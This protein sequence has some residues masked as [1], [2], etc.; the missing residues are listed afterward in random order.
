[1][2]SNDDRH[3]QLV[4]AAEA[5]RGWVRG[6]RAEWDDV[7]LGIPMDTPAPFAAVYAPRSAPPAAVEVVV[8]PAMPLPQTPIA[9]ETGSDEV[10]LRT[11]VWRGTPSLIP[12]IATLLRALREPLIEH[13]RQIAM[14]AVIAVLVGSAGWAARYYQLKWAA[15]P[16]TGT[17]TLESIPPG[18][19]VLIDGAAAGTAPLTTELEPGRHVVEFR[20]RD[21]TQTVTIDV[22]AGQSTLG[23]VDWNAR[24]TGR[25][26]VDSS[27][28]GARV[29]IDGRDRGVTPLAVEDLPQ[30]S[31]TVVLE[32]PAGSV[33]RT[34]AITAGH[35]TEIAE[36][37]YSGWLH[38]SSPIELQIGTGGREIRLDERSQAI[39]PP[40]PHEIWVEN[41]TLA[42][43]GVYQVEIEPG[44]TASISVVP[45]PSALTVTASAPGEVF[46]DGQRAGETPLTD[47]PVNLGTRDIVVRAAS[48]AERRFTTTVTTVPVR[49]DVDFSKP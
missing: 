17:A 45:P 23:R 2:V 5:L 41:R 16:R 14:A 43:R 3:A 30:G 36:T 39:L 34:A 10:F 18:S 24:R 15:M 22:A 19:E 44:E 42:Y 40:G 4:A 46:V 11:H 26:R 7:P 1:V 49:L 33:R 32:S 9:S 25:L 12:E 29:I 21:A 38:V 47:Y 6:R 37:I 35:T 8:A 20:R 13:A 27:P 48:G 31:H 28:A